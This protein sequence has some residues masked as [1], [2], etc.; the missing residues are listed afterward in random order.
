MITGKNKTLKHRTLELASQAQSCKEENPE[1]FKEIVS[2]IILLNQGLIGYFARKYQS[3]N[4]DFDEMQ[5]VI[6]LSLCKAANSFKPLSE[7][8]DWVELYVRNDLKRY[9]R[10]EKKQSHQSLYIENNGNVYERFQ[11]DS[12]SP[13]ERLAQRETLEKLFEEIDNLDNRERK[14]I[15]RRYSLNGEKTK[16]TDFETIGRELG[17]SR[18][19]IRKIDIEARRE[20]Q[21]ALEKC[22]RA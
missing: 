6:G 10:D 16:K 1:R 4:I 13:F 3:W 8:I 14:V 20:L 21:A 11:S 12:L 7:F 9:I 2:E 18:E 5:G 17:F 19:T 22:Y 15:I